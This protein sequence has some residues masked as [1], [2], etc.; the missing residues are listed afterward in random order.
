MIMVYPFDYKFFFRVIY[1]FRDHRD[2]D[3]DALDDR[4][5]AWTKI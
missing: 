3:K 2:P 5:K 1:I 4:E